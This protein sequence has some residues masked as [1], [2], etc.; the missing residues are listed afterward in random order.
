M[1]M[2][3]EPYLTGSELDWI[4]SITDK[5]GDGNLEYATFLWRKTPAQQY[6]PKWSPPS[7]IVAQL[8]TV[9][10]VAPSLPGDYLQ[11]VLLARLHRLIEE[12]LPDR[13]NRTCFADGEKY[14]QEPR[15][16]FTLSLLLSYL[17]F[18]LSAEEASFLVESA[19]GPGISSFLAA[20]SAGPTLMELTTW[21]KSKLG[22][23]LASL[24]KA[25]SDQFMFTSDEWFM[26]DEM[27]T[28]E[29]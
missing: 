3:T 23:N 12:K 17:P 21:A 13:A 25:L 16:A 20:S 22:P 14:L 5:D 10:R 8:K 18:G 28:S 6:R 7:S 24:R 11:K 4:V 19:K 26:P 27:S 9:Q 29:G 2:Q 1:L 15:F